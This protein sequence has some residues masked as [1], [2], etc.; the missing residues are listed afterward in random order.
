MRKVREI[1]NKIYDAVEEGTLTWQQVAEGALAWMSEQQVADM[2]RSEEFFLYEDLEDDED[3]EFDE[4]FTSLDDLTQ[5]ARSIV[6]DH[7]DQIRETELPH[8][9]GD[10]VY[11]LAY[12]AV[13]GNG[14]DDIQARIIAG[15]MR[16]QF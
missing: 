2:A 15:Y 3:V 10:A 14:G 16:T 8:V 7:I 1:T 11:Q 12:D 13:I 6:E 5:M 4:D 9:I